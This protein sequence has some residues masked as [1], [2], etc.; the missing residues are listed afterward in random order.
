MNEGSA[1]WGPATPIPLASHLDNLPCFFITQS[2]T[3][4]SVLG[5]E[6]VKFLASQLLKG[7]GKVLFHVLHPQGTW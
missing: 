2:P 3:Y 1:D 6:Q 5:I 7:P 4:L